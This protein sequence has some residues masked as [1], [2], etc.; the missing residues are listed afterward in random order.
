MNHEIVTSY[1]V[2]A[3]PYLVCSCGLSIRLHAPFEDDSEWRS[4]LD[5][6]GVFGE[7]VERS[8]EA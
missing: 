7:F 1:V 6:A 3:N 5:A 8:V 2:N 4:H